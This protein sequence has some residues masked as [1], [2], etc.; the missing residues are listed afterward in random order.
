[1]FGVID[2]LQLVS[3]ECEMRNSLR[4]LGSF[5]LTGTSSEG[6]LPRLDT[7]SNG[8]LF[9]AAVDDRA[10]PQV[11]ALDPKAPPPHSARAEVEQL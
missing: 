2:D 1:M 3:R 5:H 10:A 9:E 4:Q 6:N 7:K 11:A 8:S